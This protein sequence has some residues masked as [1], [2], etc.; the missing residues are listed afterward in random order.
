MIVMRAVRKIQPGN[1]HAKTHKIAQHRF[2]I[3]GGPNGADNFGSTSSRSGSW[4][5]VNCF[6]QFTCDQF[7]LPQD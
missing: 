3:A 7:R 4:H 5:F 2:R 6:V 1:V